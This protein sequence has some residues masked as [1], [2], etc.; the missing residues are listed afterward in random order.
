VFDC[1]CFVLN[2]DTENLVK[3]G[4][5]ADERIFLSYATNNL[6][7][8][9][10]NKWLMIIEESMHMVFDEFNCK[11]LD[12][13]LKYANEEDIILEKQPGTVNE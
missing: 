12:Q 10:Y 4:A 3:F 9:V 8:K 13:V 1:K 7:Y 2:N 6:A 5:K 11:L